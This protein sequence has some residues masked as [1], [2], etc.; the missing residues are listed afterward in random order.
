MTNT[1]AASDVRATWFSSNPELHPNVAL[2]LVQNEETERSTK[3]R[4]LVF[5]QTNIQVFLVSNDQTSLGNAAP[6]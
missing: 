4:R 1:G 3:G 2:Y 5:R 6:N